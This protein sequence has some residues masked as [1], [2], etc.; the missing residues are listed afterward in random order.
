MQ[1]QVYPEGLQPVGRTHTGVGEECKEE[2][3]AERSCYGLTPAPI[4]HPS[5][6]PEG[7]GRGAGNE[8][9]KLS[10]GRREVGGGF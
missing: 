10:L 5:A 7:R 2:G 1:E 8:G 9:V 3:A 6:P 4:P